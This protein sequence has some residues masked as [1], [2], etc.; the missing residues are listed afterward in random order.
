[1]VMEGAEVNMYVFHEPS[2]PR[3]LGKEGIVH[4]VSGSPRTAVAH[5]AAG[6]RRKLTPSRDKPLLMK[7][8]IPDHLLSEFLWGQTL[9]PNVETNR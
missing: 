1:M 7:K 9:L 8:S 4:S 5:A 3:C 2:L 6:G